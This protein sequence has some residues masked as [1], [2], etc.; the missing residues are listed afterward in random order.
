MKFRAGCVNA[1]IANAGAPVKNLDDCEVSVD[2]AMASRED[3]SGCPVAIVAPPP[4]IAPDPNF[5]DDDPPSVIVLD[6]DADGTDPPITVDDTPPLPTTSPPITAPPPNTAPAPI[7]APND[8]E[9]FLASVFVIFVDVVVVVVVDSPATAPS[10]DPIPTPIRTLEA[11]PLKTR[12]S[13]LSEEELSELDD[14]VDV[15][16]ASETCPADV[17]TRRD[18]EET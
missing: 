11:V 15:E 8:D 1:P 17:E 4:T 6:D 12:R 3:F 18:P 5:I 16:D 14:E 13:P 9:A 2:S 7:T 10:D